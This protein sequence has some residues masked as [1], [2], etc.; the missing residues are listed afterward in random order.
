MPSRIVEPGLTTISY[1]GRLMGEV[2][3]SNLITQLNDDYSDLAHY[4]VVL[5]SQLIIRSSSNKN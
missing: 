3:G 4:T 2:A 1:D 5:P